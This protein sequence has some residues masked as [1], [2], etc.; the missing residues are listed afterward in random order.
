[1][2]F[3][4]R[5]TQLACSRVDGVDACDRRRAARVELDTEEPTLSNQG[6]DTFLRINAMLLIF[7][8]LRVFPAR[9]QES[10]SG[11]DARFNNGAELAVTVHDP[12]GEPITSVAMVHVYRNGT[13]PSGQAATSQGRAMFVLTPLGDFTVV[14]EAA[15]YERAQREVSLPTAQRA[16]ID[17][18]LRRESGGGS[19][20]GAGAAVT[21]VPG[22]PVLA[23]K[24]KEEFEKGLQALGAEK[25]GNAEKHVSEAM[26]LAPGNPDVLYV[27]GV[28]DLKERNWAGAQAALEKAT[29][30]DPSHARAFAALGMALSDQ[31][32][33]DAAIAPLEKALALDAAVGWE[34]EWTLAK[35][36]YQRERY[37]DTLKMSQAALEASKG[38][39]PQIVLL[40]AQAL[41]AVGRYEDAEEELRGFVKEHGDRVE[42]V[43]ARRWLQKLEDRKREA[44]N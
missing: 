5:A 44:K 29:Q 30:I 32:K 34:A 27:R 14:V 19:G 41:T 18:Y 42:V 38:R 33:Y 13:T 43:T 20:T 11:A 35:A 22:R 7:V 26:R 2:R 3:F 39:A 10:G 4:L 31:G 23:P 1:M 25:L 17:I 16:Q 36:Y 24:A 21:S 8:T 9:C 28:L 15:G 40:V 6:W 12:L 37:D